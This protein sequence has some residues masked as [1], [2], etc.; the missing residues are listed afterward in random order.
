MKLQ[1]VRLMVL[2]LGGLVSWFW[3]REGLE[4]WFLE[5]GRLGLWFLKPG[6]IR[7]VV[8]KVLF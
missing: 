2:Q 8:F 7:V 6:G 5:P 3:K 4:S 1:R